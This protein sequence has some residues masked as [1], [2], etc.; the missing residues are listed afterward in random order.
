MP[1]ELYMNKK[2]TASQT[3]I[4]LHPAAKINLS[5]VVFGVR[6][7]GFHDLHTVMA[8]V[9][10]CDDLTLELT[11]RGGIELECVGLESPAG[12]DN[13][14]YRAAELFCQATN[15]SPGVSIRLVKR[16]PA[17]AG[18]GG[19]SSDA[20]ACLAGMNT[21]T[22]AG[23]S[24]AELSKLAGQ[25][26]SDVPFFLFGPAA[27]C[28]GRGEIVEPLEIRCSKSILLILTG[29]EISTASV[30][31][32]YRHEPAITRA[33][34]MDVQRLLDEHDLDALGAMGVNGLTDTTM[35]L[36]PELAELRKSIENVGIGPVHMSGSGSSLF[37]VGS[38]ED[39]AKWH[40][41]LADRNI[42]EST[43][44]T[45]QDQQDIFPEVHHERDGGKNKAG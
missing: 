40:R 39:T 19:A 16:I 2:T 26:G 36:S 12:P 10:L 29:I 21:L 24:R 13:L 45:F 1:T 41:E 7:D 44:L 11:S 25:L 35:R 14:V 9:N 6:E 31:R 23:L 22:R 3:S 5:L 33:A 20:A 15:Q 37:V 30:Y 4:N 34:M 17:G 42:A 38:P 18:L 28:S 27:I 32:Q 8:T 43:V